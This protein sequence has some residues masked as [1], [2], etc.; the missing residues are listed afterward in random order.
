MPFPTLQNGRVDKLV[1]SVLQAYTNPQFI[2][3]GILPA[4]PGLKEESGKIGAISNSHLRVYDSRRALND[5]G[6]HRMEFSY[7]QDDSY[8]VEYFDLEVFLPDRLQNQLD[9]PFNARRDAATVLMQALMLERENALAAALTSTAVLTQNVTLAGGDKFSDFANSS[10]EDVIET[11]RTAVFNAIGRD[12]NAMYM[13]RTV[14]NTLKRHPFF[15]QMVKG[16]NILSP[17]ALAQ[18]IKDYFQLDFLFVGKSVKVSSAEGQAE[19]KTSVWGDDVVLF[20][21]P[22]VGSLYEPAFGYQF[23]LSGQNVRTDIRRHENDLGDIV[24]VMW[25]Y[26]DKIL[27]TNA[28]YLIKAAI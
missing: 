22:T 2:A 26:Q 24:R 20:Y 9:Q 27:D 23:V 10:P 15:L 8:R 3:S 19:T 13:S 28:G 14:F 25:A 18:L 5:E 17:D 12:P 7:S 4:V 1:T 16:L 6:Q 21:R 11:G